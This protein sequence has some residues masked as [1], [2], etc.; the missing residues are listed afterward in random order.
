[1]KIKVSKARMIESILKNEVSQLKSSVREFVYKNP[2][3]TYGNP[4]TLEEIIDRFIFT[5]NLLSNLTESIIRSNLDFIINESE[6]QGTIFSLLKDI[7]YLKE[8][9]TILENILSVMKDPDAKFRRVAGFGFGVSQ[10]P[11][12]M[13]PNSSKDINYYSSELKEVEK[14]IR[15]KTGLL[16]I[17]NERNEITIEDGIKL[18]L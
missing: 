15:T 11:V 14:G 18:Y 17:Y 7:E 10:E 8:K 2:D 6:F 3:L 5:R 1:M 12:K 13:I 9:K 16:N 4:D